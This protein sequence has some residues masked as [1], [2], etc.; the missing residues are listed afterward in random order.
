MLTYGPSLALAQG[1]YNLFLL[2]VYYK[3]IIQHGKE[4]E[5][6]LLTSKTAI[7]KTLQA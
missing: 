3:L 5:V 2:N 1:I 6:N 7:K 4:I